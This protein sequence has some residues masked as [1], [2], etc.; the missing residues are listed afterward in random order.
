MAPET[1]ITRGLLLP[2]VGRYHLGLY[3]D[4]CAA[5]FGQPGPWRFDEGR[6]GGWLRT[7]GIDAGQLRYRA[8][9]QKLAAGQ[10]W[11][12]GLC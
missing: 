10:R 11:G 9:L 5:G 1:V 12:W 4:R 2:A 6:R 3:V 8:V 7:W